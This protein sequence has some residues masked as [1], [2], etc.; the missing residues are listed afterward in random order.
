MPNLS[1]PYWQA[2]EAEQ[3]SEVIILFIFFSNHFFLFWNSPL[4][5]VEPVL[6]TVCEGEEW[7][8]GEAGPYMEQRISRYGENHFNP[9]PVSESKWQSTN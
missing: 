5:S 4:P 8:E 9:K 3:P 2:Y 7:E 6:G 1:T